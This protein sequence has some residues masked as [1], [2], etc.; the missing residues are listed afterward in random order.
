MNSK[1]G[2]PRNR[3][4][5]HRPMVAGQHGQKNEL[6]SG[7]GSETIDDA[8]AIDWLFDEHVP[9]DQQQGGDKHDSEPPI[10]GTRP[11]PGQMPSA[12]AA[13][14]SREGPG[15]LRVV[16][17]ESP[18]DRIFIPIGKEHPPSLVLKCTTC[19]L[20]KII[21]HPSNELV[22][23]CNKCKH[24]F[25]VVTECPACGNKLVLTQDEYHA[26]S[27]RKHCP[28]CLEPTTE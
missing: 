27:T 11:Q 25:H 20:T 23:V 7:Q 13:S 14:P 26:T 18:R 2:V 15:V 8:P 22:Y 16:P 24:P 21:A 19:N 12:S 9:A 4:A 6:S 17:S 28:V 1:R 10:A 5:R 3:G